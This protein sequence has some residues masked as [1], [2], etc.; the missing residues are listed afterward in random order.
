MRFAGVGSI[1]DRFKIFFYKLKSGDLTSWGKQI[2]K[3][4]ELFRNLFWI[5]ISVILWTKNLGHL[6]GS[7]TFRVIQEYFSESLKICTS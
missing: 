2:C 5:S 4:S 7:N 6:L 1:L 3:K